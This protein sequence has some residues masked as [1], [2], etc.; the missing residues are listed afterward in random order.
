MLGGRRAQAWRYHPAFR[1]PRHV[2][3]E[4][5]I[6]LVVAGTG[7]MSVGVERIALTAGTLVWLPPGLDHA[8]EQASED[9]D[10]VVVGFER[11]LLD[12]ALDQGTELPCFTHQVD[13]LGSDVRALAGSLLGA[14]QGSEERAVE[15][16]LVDSLVGLGRSAP[17]P[18]VGAVAARLLWEETTLG[19][20]DLARRLGINRGDLSRHFQREHRTSIASYRNRLRLVGFLRELHEQPENLMRAALSA[21]FG[22]YSQCD[23][24]FSHAFGMS[25]RAYV[26][27]GG[28]DPD[29]F[30]PWPA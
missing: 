10:L 17:R 19:R 22:S 9:F 6:N 3:D 18:S 25:P 16:R 7:V 8:L 27:G 23:R 11:E 20:D 29:R 12:R 5:E 30:E 4:S 1:R 13:R 14:A 24:V 2:H 26:H 28:I 21:G 15:E